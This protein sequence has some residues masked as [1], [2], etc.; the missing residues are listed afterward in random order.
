VDQ[1]EMAASPRANVVFPLA[2]KPTIAT[3]VGPPSQPV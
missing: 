1:A 3:M 2:G